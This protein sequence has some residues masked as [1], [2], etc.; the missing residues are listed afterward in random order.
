MSTVAIPVKEGA[1]APAEQRFLL[2]AV[3]WATY[4]AISKALTG[5]HVRLTYDRGTLEFM[6]ISS[7]HGTFS[8][9]IGRLIVVLTEELGL[10]L[11]SCGDMT[12]DREDLERSLEPDECFYIANEPAVR[13]KEEI[14]LSTDPPPD[15]A[16]EVDISRSSQR[17]LAIYAALEVPEV[18]RFNGEMMAVYQREAS[19]Q[20]RLAER[21]QIFPLLPMTEFVTFL[22][23]RTQTDENSLVRSFRARVR[24]LRRAQE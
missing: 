14:D 22:R 10:P 4:K 16:V 11:R 17:L 6:T 20:Y 13:D 7:I 15:L 19:G 21:S 8:R 2:R 12:C 5:R 24:E 18:W 23:Q 1:H 3:E 9:L